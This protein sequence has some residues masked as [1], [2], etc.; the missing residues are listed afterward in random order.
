MEVER[1]A[2]TRAIPGLPDYTIDVSGAVYN[3]QGHQMSIREWRG[4]RVVTLQLGPKRGTTVQIEALLRL[5]GWTL[6]D[7]LP[8]GVAPVPGHP[9][10]FATRE[11]EI[12]SAVGKGHRSAVR[13]RPTANPQG[14]LQVRLAGGLTRRV[15]ILV[16]LAFR[17][18]RPSRA[19]EGRHF[20]DCEK[21]NC[22]LDN[23][24]WGTKAENMADKNVHGTD[25]AGVK[26][27]RAK[28]DEA[29][30]LRIRGLYD[31][32]GREFR[33]LGREFGINETT[34]RNVCLRKTWKHVP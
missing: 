28:L 18:P 1:A 10:Y 7:P 33:E 34:S 9:G 26:N 27:G 4:K 22:R 5:S 17:G 25:A 15:H 24:S 21:T 31:G 3:R 11:G 12:W 30:V 16:L 32:G 14:Y 6:Q 19:H 29:K 2:E 20:P 23:L 13:L 8:A